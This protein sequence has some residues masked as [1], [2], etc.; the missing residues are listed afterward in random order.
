MSIRDSMERKEEYQEY[1]DRREA[2]LKKLGLVID[3]WEPKEE[4]SAEGDVGDYYEEVGRLRSRLEETRR[5]LESVKKTRD[6]WK[7]LR[8]DVDQAIAELEKAIAEAAPR[9]Q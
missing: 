8:D 6:D 3:Q 7:T 2:R 4:D 5:R 9:F 1:Y